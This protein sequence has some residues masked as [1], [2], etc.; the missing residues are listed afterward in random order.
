[1]PGILED[2]F[3][4]TSKQSDFKVSTKI[5]NGL[6]TKKKE[7]VFKLTV[8][9]KRIYLHILLPQCIRSQEVSQ[10]KMFTASFQSLVYV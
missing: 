4:A 5:N 1:M 7:T 9:A 6:I 10:T 3:L 8:F 2:M